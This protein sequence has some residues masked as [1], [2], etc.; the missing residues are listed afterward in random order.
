MSTA[1]PTPWLQLRSMSTENMCRCRSSIASSSAVQLGGLREV[2]GADHVA[3][4]AGERDA[5]PAHLGEVGRDL[6]GQHGLR[7]PAA[8]SLGD[9][10]RE[11]AHALDVARPVDRGDDDAQIGG[12]RGLQGQQRERL[13]LGAVAE[14][15]DADVLGDDLLGQLQVDLQQGSCRLGQ[16]LRDLMH[17]P[18]RRRPSSS[19]WSW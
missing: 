2:T 8:G 4:L 16:R 11:V 15:V 12:H 13:L 5:D 19:S 1:G 7:V 3:R 14:L 6:G 9:V 18:A 10:Q 17:M